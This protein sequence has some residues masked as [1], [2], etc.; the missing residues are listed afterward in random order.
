MAVSVS[1][2]KE[3]I[4][5]VIVFA[6]VGVGIAAVLLYLPQFSKTTEQEARFMQYQAAAKQFQGRM[7]DYKGVCSELAL[8]DG[9]ICADGAEGYRV[10]ERRSE[11]G[12]FCADHTGFLG[13]ISSPPA[14]AAV[15][16]LR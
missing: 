16:Q 12:Y 13:P 7:Y 11:G 5:G 1:S 10:L 4:L 14:A 6:V 9:V 2:I 3:L 15:C 8:Q